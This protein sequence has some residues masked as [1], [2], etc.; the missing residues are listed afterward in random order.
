MTNTSRDPLARAFQLLRWFTRERLES[1]GVREAAAAL[2]VAPST[3]HNLLA[4]LTAERV[5]QQ[6]ERSGRYTLGLELFQLAHQAIDQVPLRRIA[7][8]HLRRLVD[9]CNE[10]AHLSLYVRDRGSLVTIAGVESTH[11]IRYVIDMYSWRPL[12]VGAAGWAVLA[13]LPPAERAALLAQ[14]PAGAAKGADNDLATELDAVRTRGYAFT[15]GTRI[16]GAVGLAAPLLDPAGS[17]IGAV[18]LAL[19][20]QRFSPADLGRLAKPL[21]ACARNLMAEIGTAATPGG[22]RAKPVPR[23]KP[24]LSNA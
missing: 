1:I 15:R 4:A 20:E 22:R 10:A 14:R 24:E 2:S 21:L 9:A 7:M 17:P 3:A 16:E 5:L 23:K 12:H 8:P 13:M 19:P 6:D 11:A 18:G